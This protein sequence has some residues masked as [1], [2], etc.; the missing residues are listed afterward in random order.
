MMIMCALKANY[1]NKIGGNDSSRRTFHL[2][3][4]THLLS[5]SETEKW[6]EMTLVLTFYFHS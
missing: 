2:N 5:E 6:P 4:E 3:S 1:I